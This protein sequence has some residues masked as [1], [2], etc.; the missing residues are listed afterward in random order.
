V[1]VKPLKITKT[2]AY[3]LIFPAAVV[4]IKSATNA[5]PYDEP[6]RGTGKKIGAGKNWTSIATGAGS[7]VLLIGLGAHP[8][9]R[10]ISV[11]RHKGG[12]QARKGGDYKVQARRK[13]ELLKIFIFHAMNTLPHVARG[14]NQK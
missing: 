3:D 5:D 14:E 1:G 11:A 13:L 2:D 12:W 4:E 10:A 8:A 7:C 9:G 6:P